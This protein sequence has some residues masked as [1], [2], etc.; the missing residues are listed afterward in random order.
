MVRFENWGRRTAPDSMMMRGGLQSGILEN[1]LGRWHRYS[2]WRQGLGYV[3]RMG[4]WGKVEN[5]V[6]VVEEV[7]ELRSQNSEKKKKII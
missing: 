5:K 4:T 6:F 2:Y 1:E 7:K 3:H